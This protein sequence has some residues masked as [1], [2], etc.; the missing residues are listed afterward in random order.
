MLE[1]ICPAWEP[2][3]FWQEWDQHKRFWRVR[4]LQEFWSGKSFFRTGEESHRSY[5]LARVMVEELAKNWESFK[6]F[7]LA[8]DSKDAGA[9]AA[10]E[11]MG[12]DLGEV[13]SG[14]LQRPSSKKWAPNPRI[15]RLLRRD[16]QS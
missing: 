3:P 1:A 2:Y 8:A 6:R 16:E 13:F 9:R 12:T 10:R 14:L 4:E 7:V 15:W 5:Q 11:E